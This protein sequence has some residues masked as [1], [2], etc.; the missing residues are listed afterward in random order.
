MAATLRASSSPSWLLA[1]APSG[2]SIERSLDSLL[3]ASPMAQ[4]E[5]DSWEVNNDMTPYDI[6]AGP[7]GAVPPPPAPPEVEADVAELVE[8][9]AATCND[10]EMRQIFLGALS[11]FAPFMQSEEALQAAKAVK[12][13]DALQVVQACSSLSKAQGGGDACPICLDNISEGQWTRTLPC[14]HSLHKKCAAKYYKVPG[15]KACCPVCRHSVAR[16]ATA[17]MA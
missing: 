12:V 7:D 11:R 17:D 1:P 15:V 14:L 13:A 9:F 6:L 5:E 8:Q 2:V 16:G 4:A 3:R 10:D